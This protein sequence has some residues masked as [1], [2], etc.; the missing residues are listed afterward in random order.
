MS[1]N[2]GMTLIELIMVLLI[3]S[4]CLSLAWPSFD[5]A[6]QHYALDAASS[7]LAWTL[8]SARSEAMLY[9][10]HAY[11]RFYVPVDRYRS[12]EGIYQLSSG[13]KFA[14]IPT[15]P[16]RIGTIPVCIFSPSGAPAGGGTVVLKNRFSDKKYIIVNPAAGRIR[17]SDEAPENW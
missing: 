5:R 2:R 7:H 4:V 10:E 6:Y 11:V 13:V 15:F 16:S 1:D 12:K 8:R 3:L 17:V 14:G 9:G